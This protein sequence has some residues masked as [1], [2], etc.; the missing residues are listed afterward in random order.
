VESTDSPTLESVL[1]DILAVAARLRAAP[2]LDK[3]HIESIVQVELEELSADDLPTRYRGS[4]AA[5]WANQVEVRVP[6]LPGKGG[7]FVDLQL[8]DG[9]DLTPQQLEAR[10]S[11][12]GPPTPI[13]PPPP[14]AAAPKWEP[15]SSH[16]FEQDG[17]TT[18][19]SFVGAAPRLESV[20]V[21][22]PW[23]YARQ[24]VPSPAAS[25][26]LDSAAYRV[27]QHTE[28]GRLWH[29]M[30][31]GEEEILRVHAIERVG[32]ALIVDYSW[33]AYGLTHTVAKRLINDV[34]LTGFLSDRYRASGNDVEYRIVAAP[35]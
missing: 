34:L 3:A 9:I 12:D 29:S 21:K 14:R 33:V 15:R 6:T 5:A 25:G 30:H 10:V 27:L 26:L 17:Q 7:W 31:A 23:G 8:A 13:A 20:L 16:V 2:R 11:F 35:N 22:R 19:F 18:V 28:S 1:D 32:T 4:P 24:Q